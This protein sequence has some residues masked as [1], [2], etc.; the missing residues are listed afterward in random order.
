MS[1]LCACAPLQVID[2]NPSFNRILANFRG[3][4]YQKIAVT[5][6]VS[7]PFGYFA[8]NFWKNTVNDNVLR[9]MSTGTSRLPLMRVPSMFMAGG[10]GLL[11]GFCLA[12]QVAT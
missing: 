6:A 9:T 4:D 12:Y 11:G 3:E 7:L 10:I 1:L 2:S 5:T 8:G